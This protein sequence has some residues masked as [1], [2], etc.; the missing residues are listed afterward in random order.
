MANHYQGF[1]NED[2]QELKNHLLELKFACSMVPTRRPERNV[3]KSLKTNSASL[4]ETK[5]A[6]IEKVESDLEAIVSSIF[7]QEEHSSF[8][9]PASKASTDLYNKLKEIRDCDRDCT[10]EDTNQVTSLLKRFVRELDP[11]HPFAAEPQEDSLKG[12][13]TDVE[14]VNQPINEDADG[15]L[16]TEDRGVRDPD[17]QDE[18]MGGFEAPMEDEE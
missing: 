10:E 1:A 12:G 13:I 17:S 14:D 18:P 7:I 2:L 6:I 8:H 3:K 9:L 16:G 15:D 11:N 4:S 5:E